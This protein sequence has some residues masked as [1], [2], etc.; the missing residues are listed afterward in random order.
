MLLL[1]A[2]LTALAVI[3]IT[4]LLLQIAPGR[5]GMTSRLEEVHPRR[6]GALQESEGFGGAVVQVHAH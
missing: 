6:R 2:V 3:S 4:V 1:I 5:G